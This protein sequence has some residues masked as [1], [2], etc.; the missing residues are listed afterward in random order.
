MRASI[1]PVLF[2]VLAL[3]ATGCVTRRSLLTTTPALPLPA[4]FAS[5][6]DVQAHTRLTTHV[7][8]QQGVDPSAD[9]VLMT[10]RAEVGAIGTIRIGEVFAIRPLFEL[11]L[12]QGALT[13]T[14]RETNLGEVPSLMTG[15]GLMFRVSELHDTLTI[16]FEIDPLIGFTV[17]RTESCTSDFRTCTTTDESLEWGVMPRGSILLAYQM[18]PWARGWIAG[19]AALQPDSSSTVTGVG[20]VGTGME[21]TPT[22]LF[23]FLVSIEWPF[24]G[25][26]FA[27]WPTI[28]AAA[29][30]NFER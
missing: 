20:V 10:P 25:S 29:R 3:A 30:F 12:A 15:P 14:A 13:G 9:V 5:G 21:L 17:L 7:D 1:A 11:G 24:A 4:T 19:G 18:A 6:G 16:D 2:T 27:Y 28:A 22:D 23:T 26:P 8:P